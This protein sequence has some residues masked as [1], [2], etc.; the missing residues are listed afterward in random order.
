MRGDIHTVLFDLYDTLVTNDWSANVRLL[1]DRLE[2]ASDTVVA[3]YDDLRHV[4]DEGRLPDVRV[5][6]KAVVT[7]CGVDADDRLIDELV[8]AEAALLAGSVRWYDDSLDGLRRLR[9]DGYRTGV[10][11]NCSPSTRPVVERLGVEDEADVV[12]LSCEVGASK[13][14]PDVYRV[15]LDALGSPA[16]GSLFVD[17]RGDYLDGAAGLGMETVRIVRPVAHGED[18]PGGAHPVITDLNGLFQLL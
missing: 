3:A 11:S 8:E 1:S 2:V 7:A 18:V 5:T 9:A 4:R 15:A 14:S 6:M 17:D 12:V 16:A 13:P 10:I